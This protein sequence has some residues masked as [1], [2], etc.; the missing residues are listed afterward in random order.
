[1][2]LLN[3]QQ[4][5]H[6]STAI[7]GLNPSQLAWVSGYLAGLSS[8]KRD[9]QFYPELQ[10]IP[11]DSKSSNNV[12]VLYGS[13]TGNSKA[14]AEELH[15]NLLKAGLNSSLSN[16]LD[17]RSGQLKKEQKVF[18]VISTQGNGEP[19][20]EAL[21]F[22]KF[23]ESKRA[24]NLENLEYSVL[25]LGD[26]SYDEYCQTGIDLD[27][28]LES[29]GASRLVERVDADIDFED[30]AS[31]WQKNI[32]ENVDVEENSVSV[33]NFNSHPKA[34]ENNKKWNEANPYQAE[35]L[36]IIN[37]TDKGS[38]QEAYH[39][40]LALDDY[41]FTYQAGDILAFLPKNQIELVENII[42]KLGF[43]PSEKI[44]IKNTQISLREALIS[45]LDINKLTP[46]VVKAYA[47]AIDSTELL[48]A[49]K[50]KKKFKDF[51]QRANALD[52]LNAYPG[53]LSA[54]QFVSSLRP[55]ISR[56]YSIS[57]SAEIHTDE[58]HILVKPLEYDFVG[59][60]HNGSASSFVKQLKDGD[61]IPV[62]IKTNSSFKLP[63]DPNE[64][65]IMI[66]AGTG[67]APY[68]S[69]L[70]ERESQGGFGNSWL[71]FGE[72]HFQSDFLYQTDWQQF[73]KNG[74]LE[75]M[76]VAFSRDQKQKVYVQHKLLEEAEDIYKWLLDG[77]TLY[78]CGDIKHMAADV[79][80]ALIQIISTQSEKTPDE[81]EKWLEE[82]QLSN[83]YQRDVY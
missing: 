69:F 19:P 44:T 72:Q 60:Q 37:L 59:Y 17:Y 78:V 50:D 62:H 8:E 43:D 75:R 15:G 57:S 39:I 46:T 49:L 24:P 16:L 45:K 7:Q 76:N 41:G 55:L 51:T 32:L 42:S 31:V 74:V 77:A 1:M 40:E 18:F 48:H 33:I 11:L 20:D 67:V 65:I 81:A 71:F 22:I 83:K 34:V 10:S 68:R 64:K 14:I 36:K 38:T 9:G 23:I 26:S 47:K 52:L 4:I 61:S 6:V 56:Q 29:L 70:F 27:A 2:T 30:S 54:Q 80:Q 5:E 79:H 58:V 35:I 82:K 25:G 3:H 53:I 12:T 73:L 66:G 28:R 21:G 13:Q 63:K